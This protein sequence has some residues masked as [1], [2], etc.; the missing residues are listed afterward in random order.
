MQVT[1]FDAVPMLVLAASRSDSWDERTVGDKM[2]IANAAIVSAGVLALGLVS[3]QAADL[4]VKA[5]PMVAAPVPFS[6][7]GF[8]IG[9]HVG[10]KRGR[11]ETDSVRDTV[12]GAFPG[13]ITIGGIPAP[14]ALV[15]VPSRL[16]TIPGTSA[17]NTG[18]VGGGQI[19]Y[20]W[21][22]SNWVFGLE[23]DANWNSIRAG[24]GLVVPDPFLIATLTG[25]T[26]T[27]IDWTASFRGRVG[28]TFDRLLVYATGGGTVAGG[29]FSSSFT[30][31]NPITGIFFPIPFQGTTNASENFS[32]LGWTVGGGLEYA[33]DRN[34]SIAGEYR[35][36]DYGTRTVT[37]ANTD[38]AG[39][40]SLG[41][42]PQRVNMRLRTDEAT[43]RLNYRF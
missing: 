41:I 42:V 38:P 39:A 25:T 28:V 17:T 6:W 8:Y 22:A 27:Q 11:A 5:P 15:L 16:A 19:G 33:F 30:L 21:Q 2:K 10:A 14:A 31:T 37:L 3:A 40:A 1:V 32:R 24:G 13:F 4:P 18:F 35:Y 29:R 43:L 20:N 34:W 23:A 12:N 26:N 7:T 36:S 9:G